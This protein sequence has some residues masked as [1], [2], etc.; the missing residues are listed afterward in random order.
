M[1][2][3]ISQGSAAPIGE[4]YLRPGEY[5]LSALGDD[6][7]TLFSQHITVVGAAP[8]PAQ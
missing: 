4:L 1:G 3:R 7:E 6:N 8:T 5:T 2:D